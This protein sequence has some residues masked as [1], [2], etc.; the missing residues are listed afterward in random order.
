MFLSAGSRQTTRS[1][2]AGLRWADGF[3]LQRLPELLCRHPGSTSGRV[4]FPRELYEHNTVLEEGQRSPS[5]EEVCA[6]E[7]TN[8][9]EPTASPSWRLRY[10]TCNLQDTE[11][12]GTGHHLTRLRLH[13]ALNKSL[14]HDFHIWSSLCVSRCWTGAQANVSILAALRESSLQQLV[15][16]VNHHRYTNI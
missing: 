3:R 10:F 15:W 9:F 6:A 7:V 11:S 13:V 5:R 14:V 12:E 16:L 8:G 4:Q 1:R 2:R